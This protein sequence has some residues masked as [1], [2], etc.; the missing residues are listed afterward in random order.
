MFR[1]M[2]LK[3]Q[4][5]SETETLEILRSCTSGVLAVAGDDGYPYTV[6]LSYACQ[7]GKLVFHC[8]KSGHKIDSIL[9]Q[10]K[11]SFCVIEKD[12]VIAETLTTH[13][14]SAVV[15]GRARI[16]TDD[17]ERRQALECLAK[18]YSPDHLKQAQ[19][20]IEREWKNVCLVEI[21]IEHMT[22]KAAS[23]LLDL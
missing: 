14:R 18:K 23:E 1:A 2:R 22:G 3:K 5:L 16:L 21:A 9:K 20:E 10:D 13:Y 17:N 8:A 6:P 19:V 11:V 15:F 12:Q 7:D 4:Q